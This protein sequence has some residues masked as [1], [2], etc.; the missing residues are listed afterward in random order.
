VNDGDE[1]DILLWMPDAF[2]PDGDGLNDRF[3]AV[4]RNV[5]QFSMNIY[6]RTGQ[7]LYTTADVSGGW[8]GTCN[9]KPCPAGG[10]VYI[11]VYES[12]AAP[13]EV[14]T[15]TGNITLVR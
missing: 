9:G 7:L 11:V 1:C 8:D 12:S 3:H 5:N 2:S 4:T 15:I 10:Y 6:S 14:R 13:P